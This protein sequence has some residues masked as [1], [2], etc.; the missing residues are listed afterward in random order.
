[1]R[2]RV[3]MGFGLTPENRETQGGV[4]D[5][6]LAENYVLKSYYKEPYSNRFGW[7]NKKRM[8]D[9]AQVQLENF[10]VRSADGW[11]S[12]LGDLSG[13]NRQK[14]IVA[15]EIALADKLLVVSQPTRGLDVGSIEYIHRRI[16]EHRDQGKAILL[17]SFELDEILNLCDRIA[18]ISHGK[19]VG[20]LDAK[21]ATKQAVGQMM[22]TTR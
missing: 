12:M 3:E 2:Q 13:G 15:R 9:D 8:I 19:I 5:F 10:D 22:A 18:A 16:I 14:L 21:D 17:I 11:R 1:M 7:L 4:G 20:V 6:N